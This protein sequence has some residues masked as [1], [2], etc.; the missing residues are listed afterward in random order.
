MLGAFVETTDGLGYF[1]INGWGM[2]ASEHETTHSSER[3]VGPADQNPGYSSDGEISS[4]FQ[5]SP[6][7]G[8]ISLRAYPHRQNPPIFQSILLHLIY[9]RLQALL[10]PYAQQDRSAFSVL[11]SF[12]CA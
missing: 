8:Q 2:R 1:A 4:R 6:R 10:R 12:C 7:A 9:P 11:R 3:N 5:S